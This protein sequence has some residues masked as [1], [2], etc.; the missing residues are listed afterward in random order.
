MSQLKFSLKIWNNILIGGRRAPWAHLLATPLLPKVS[1]NVPWQ[2][3]SGQLCQFY[4]VMP[5]LCR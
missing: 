2:K 1:K 5:E 3:K 4:P